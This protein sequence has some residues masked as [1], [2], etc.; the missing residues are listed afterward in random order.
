MSG[1]EIFW[2][3]MEVLREEDE[4]YIALH[5]LS[6][7]QLE[8]LNRESPNVD[9]IVA[10]MSEKME[11]AAAIVEIEPKRQEAVAEWAARVENFTEAQRG[12]VAELRD[13]MLET[14]SELKEME[15]EIARKIERCG[16]EIN[17]RLGTLQRQKMGNI[18]YTPRPSNGA[19]YLDRRS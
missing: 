4:E 19:R 17:M 16:D 1:I 9:R 8:E 14:I 13:A 6:K 3:L 2:R 12:D 11:I 10:L 7:E 18:A 5:R 15:E